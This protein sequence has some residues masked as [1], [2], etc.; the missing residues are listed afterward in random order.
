MLPL[1]Q[2]K[3]HEWVKQRQL[4]FQLNKLTQT[5]PGIICAHQRTRP[6]L[7]MV[8]VSTMAPRRTTTLRL[9]TP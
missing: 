7:D 3:D 5:R 6:S 2:L 1:V 8:N 9:D 4:R